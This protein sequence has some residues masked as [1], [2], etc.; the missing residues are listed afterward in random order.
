MPAVAEGIP[1]VLAV[2][3]HRLGDEIV[4]ELDGHGIA[5]RVY[6]GRDSVDPEVPG[7]KMCRDLDRAELLKGAV[8]SIS[9]KGCKHGAA[10]CEFYRDC[11]Y[12]RQQRLAPQVWIVPHQLLFLERPDFIPQP[13]SLAI[14]EAFWNASVHGTDRPYLLWLDDLEK[15]RA[16]YYPS[17]SGLQCDLGASNDLLV[18]SQ[19][20]AHLLRNEADGRLRRPSLVEAGIT[21]EDLKT[22]LRLEWRRKIEPDV[23]PGMPL[24]LVRERCRRII[25]H[26]QMVARLAQFWRLL[27]D[28]FEATEIERSPWL[29][30]QKAMPSPGGVGVA[31]AV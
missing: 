29:A 23:E 30:F 28:T 24:P 2:P 13:G 10:E 4:I 27:A 20:L 17:S 22:A 12:Q 14:D 26:N 5:G 21:L 11:G 15:Y 3:R 19:R 16:V 8:A 7:Q 1:I 18:I 25:D 31:P 9:Q 6:R